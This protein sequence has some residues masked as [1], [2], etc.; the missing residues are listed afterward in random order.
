MPFSLPSF[1]KKTPA[2]SLRCYFEQ[3]GLLLDADL[4]W[5][6]DKRML[7]AALL[8]D[9]Q[10]LAPEQREAVYINFEDVQQLGD[11]AGQSALRTWVVDVE[12]FDQLDGAEA[13]G[14]FVLAANPKGFAHALSMAYA[15]RQY[16]GRMWGGYYVSQPSV[17]SGTTEALAVFEAE[18][19]SIF[20]DRDGSGRKLKVERFERP[21]TAEPIFQYSI[22][23]ESTPQSGLEF[24]DDQPCRTTRRPVIEATLAYD[25]ADGT[26]DIV[27]RG[28]KRVRE[29]VGEAFCETLLGADVELLP[30][31]QREFDLDRLRAPG[32]LAFDPADGIR[33]V[34]VA[35]LRLRDLTDTTG[36]VT[37]DATN[38]PKSLYDKSQDWFGDANPLQSPNWTVEQAKLQILFHPD[39]PGH[40]DKKV[41]IELRVP[42]GSNIKEQIRHH[43]VI[44]SKYLARWGLLRANQS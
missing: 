25:P 16:H 22:F 14:L 28:S 33:A 40:K 34:S 23:V 15:A 8:K 29:L 17:P 38:G 37:L 3:R 18:L 30:V 43:D 31:S 42:N 13:K 11:D 2:S 21:G 10:S 9:V 36:R 7:D 4:D 24:I 20:A 35:T 44:A 41:S 5:S 32:E 39:R 19:R 27:A 26:I 6:G 1:I 12:T